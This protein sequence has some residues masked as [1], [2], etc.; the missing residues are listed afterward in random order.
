MDTDIY[1]LYIY[2][3]YIYIY[4]YYIYIYMCLYVLL[5][6]SW[7]VWFGF[8]DSAMISIGTVEFRYFAFII[9][10]TKNLGNWKLDWSVSGSWDWSAFNEPLSLKQVCGFQTWT[11]IARFLRFAFYIFWPRM[12]WV[13]NQSN[14]LDRILRLYCYQPCP[15]D[16][17]TNIQYNPQ[18]G[19]LW[20]LVFIWVIWF[21]THEIEIS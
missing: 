7:F 14:L 2:N 10:L 6:C 19:M 4:I 9:I 21:M 13:Y 18:D 8:R 17:C 16:Y 5:C 3:I 20:T 1:I 15:Q 12:S 11:F